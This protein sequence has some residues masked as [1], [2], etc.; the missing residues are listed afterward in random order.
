MGPLAEEDLAI[1]LLSRLTAHD[2]LPLPGKS[3]GLR[4]TWRKLREMRESL[5]AYQLLAHGAVVAPP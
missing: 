3:A 4:D 1:E 2:V 5:R